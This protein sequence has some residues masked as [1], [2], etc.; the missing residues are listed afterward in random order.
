MI[1]PGLETI[2]NALFYTLYGG[3]G[4]VLAHEAA[5]IPA[6]EATAR[7]LEQL[8][9]SVGSTVMNPHM[10]AAL[11]NLG[12][13]SA[14]AAILYGANHCIKKATKKN[15]LERLV[16]PER[17]QASV[18]HRTFAATMSTIPAVLG[19]ALLLGSYAFVP[20]AMHTL[21][22][23]VEQ[24][25]QQLS[26]GVG[27]FYTQYFGSS[28]SLVMSAVTR[29]IAALGIMA[30]GAALHARWA[31]RKHG[32]ILVRYKID[33]YTKPYEKFF[34]L[35]NLGVWINAKFGNMFKS[36]S[37]VRLADDTS[38]AAAVEKYDYRTGQ[39]EAGYAI[40][41]NTDLEP[42]RTK[43]MSMDVFKQMR[44]TLLDGRKPLLGKDVAARAKEPAVQQAIAGFGHAREDVRA[45]LHALAAVPDE[46]LAAIA[47][48][49]LVK[50]YEYMGERTAERKF[51]RV[52]YEYDNTV[53]EQSVILT[54]DIAATKRESRRGYG[55]DFVRRHELLPVLTYRV[56]KGSTED[57]VEHP[58]DTH[59]DDEHDAHA[60]DA[61][62]NV[63]KAW[64]KGLN[65]LL[66]LGLGDSYTL[67]FLKKNYHY[68]E[69]W[70]RSFPIGIGKRLSRIGY[71]SDSKGDIVAKIEET[72]S[73][74]KA[75]G[76]YD[77]IVDIYD[78]ELAN[79]PA[80][81]QLLCLF[82]QFL[83]H[84]KKYMDYRLTNILVRDQGLYG[85]LGDR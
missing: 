4:L 34:S 24:G 65:Q 83:T 70:L 72:S 43:R 45:A 41:Y 84:K 3:G 58:D 28:A 33:G 14:G 13:F 15:D 71:L 78:R 8:A 31:S 6:V 63:I 38:L 66:Y 12:E 60:T 81:G 57:V 64:K 55:D 67:D 22:A 36:A 82:S 23:T 74:S 19:G 9:V 42:T 62:L 1:K 32:P 53:P 68:E 79:N 80:F 39:H 21:A 47:D 17:K 50:R 5:K 10:A 35:Q 56:M 46:D 75:L 59:T 51:R 76:N 40:G 61:Q 77:A 54:E 2:K 25:M 7:T 52:F 11:T 20:E 44:D 30:T 69:S 18:T 27:Q 16:G 85:T 48:H 49:D 73:F 29:S 26:L 37:Y